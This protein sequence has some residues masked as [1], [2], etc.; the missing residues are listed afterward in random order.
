MTIQAKM[1]VVVR[2][3]PLRWLLAIPFLLQIFLAVGG[4]GYLSY[5]NGQNAVET[6]A[7]RLLHETSD[8]I[9]EQV[10]AYTAI[11]PLAVQMNADMLETGQLDPENL[12]AW[13]SH[14][15]Q[16]SQWFEELTYIY[17]GSDRGTYVGIHHTPQNTYEFSIKNRPNVLVEVYQRQGQQ[18]QLKQTRST[19]ILERP[20]FRAV[21]GQS[22][23]QWTKTYQFIAD[24]P[25]FGISF[26]RPLYDSNNELI[27]VLGAD[28]SLGAIAEFLQQL[29]VSQSG[30][31]FIMDRDGKI[32]ASSVNPDAENESLLTPDFTNAFIKATK[33]QI[34]QQ[35]P[36]ISQI[37]QRQYFSFRYQNTHQRVQ[38]LPFP[39]ENGLDWLIV[40][41]IPETAFMGQIHQQA[42]LTFILCLIAL[43]IAITTSILTARWL[44]RP[45][46]DLGDA[47]EGIARGD[48]HRQV[49]APP[50]P[51]L[52]R[53]A[54]S[55]NRMASQLQES[56]DLLEQRVEM[57]TAELK[58]EKDKS[59]Q[60]LLNI[61]PEAITA[62]LKEDSNA[63]AENFDEVTIL[64]ADIV[65]FTPLS[66]RLQPIQLVNLL[67][68][69]F[70][71][72]DNLVEKYNLEKIKTIGDA[73]MVAAGL[74]IPRS[75][76]ADAIADMALEMQAAVNHFQAKHN[77]TLQIRIGIN[78]GVV[79]AGVIGKK[80][81]IYDLWGDAVNVASRM[82]SSG[83]PGSIQV[84]T[85]TYE[86]LKNR[87]I[88]TERGKI[89][90]KGK[91][92]MMTYWLQEKL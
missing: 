17:F 13:R 67:N 62:R 6:L 86:H 18:W 45:L 41:A 31:T 39:N 29:P 79:I 28:F 53:L 75:D 7:D 33:A 37:R 1:A 14:L 65:G 92:E 66:A 87:Y 54:Q 69:I 51:E 36:N 38:I 85:A 5:R 3:I 19:D 59:E 52:R 60:L 58:A 84:T 55:F 44:S 82:E 4:V 46:Q 50:T 61:L 73:Y 8:R 72:F 35:F 40:A 32:V 34:R 76:H 90:V 74:P 70:S 16:Q 15:V 2:R 27:G 57:R 77:E 47:A 24:P 80:K 56:F 81:F 12:A 20:W 68:E 25:V 22:Q 63:I 89:T 9:L 88:L 71:A 23:P 21:M 42:R 83:K 48:L 30:T 49:K 10:Q 78:T 91:G 64:F 11:P 43:A 26:A